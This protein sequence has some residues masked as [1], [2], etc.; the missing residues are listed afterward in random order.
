MR[1]F[2]ILFVLAGVL[3]FIA[4]Q[5]RTGIFR[6]KNPGEPANKYVRA[7][8]EAER[9]AADELR[10]IQDKF[11]NATVT[12]SGMRFIV[13]QPG[14]GSPPSVGAQVVAHYHGTLL[15][16]QK[17][18]SS[19]D[20][21][22]PFAFRVGTGAVIKGWDEAFLTMKEGERRTL[23]IPWWLAYGERGTGKIPPRATLVFE[24]ELVAIR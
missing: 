5:A 24:V 22:E 9:L 17:F 12:P 2:G 13:R 3:I 6:S 21:G 7:Q 14:S 10:L 19:Y 16:G 8:Q 11:G 20:R 4:F 15:N 23:V 18:D 1:K